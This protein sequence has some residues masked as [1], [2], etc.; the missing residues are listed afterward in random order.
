MPLYGH[1]PQDKLSA[2][3]LLC[4]HLARYRFGQ[5]D[6]NPSGETFLPYIA[7]LP[8]DFSTVPLWREVVKDST[9]AKMIA[10]DG[11]LP[12][13]LRAA[14]QDVSE[15]FWKDWSYMTSVLV[16]RSSITMKSMLTLHITR[17]INLQKVEV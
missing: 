7:T 15:R 2:I 17:L 12:Y 6:T 11:L 10:E 8:T 13:G 1:L 14:V 5:A 3:Q 4:L 16:S 9:W